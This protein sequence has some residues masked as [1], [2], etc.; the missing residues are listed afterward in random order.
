MAAYYLLQLFVDVHDD[1]LVNLYKQA[2]IKHNT[3]V[4]AYF[5]DTSSVHVDA[6]FDLFCP[7]FI[8]VLGRQTQKVNHRVKTAMKFIL[9][10]NENNLDISMS[11]GYYLYPR[12]S[13]G[14]KTPLRLAN[15]VGIID[16]GY[17][18]YLIAVFDNWQE[19]VFNIE[20]YQR[21]AQVC[22][23]NLTYP[24]YVQMVEQEEDLGVTVRGAGGFGSSGK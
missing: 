2:I 14:S 11:V 23:P 19:E 21:L 6:G 10:D 1:E 4:E 7:N 5:K 15:S 13:T 18:G 17:R 3:V 8:T 22:P 16:S 9:K 20:P 12:S 24:I